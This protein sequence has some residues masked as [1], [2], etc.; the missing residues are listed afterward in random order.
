MTEFNIKNGLV[1]IIIVAFTIGLLLLKPFNGQINSGL[2]ILLVAA[3]LWISEAIHLTATALLI[4]LM[5]T[6]LGVFPIGEALENFSHPIIFIFIGGFSLAAALQHVGLDKKMAQKIL[7]WSKGQAMRAVI[8]LFLLTAI[9]S[10]WVS[11]TAVAALMLPLALGMI[12]RLK[13]NDSNTRVF[14]LLGIAYSASIGGIGTIVGSP[15]N[16]I[17]AASLQLSFSD[18]L[19]LGL[20]IVLIL[21]PTLLGVLYFSLKPNLPKHI[22][23]NGT[24]NPTQN[25]STD[26]KKTRPVLAIFFITVVLWLVG[27]PIGQALGIHKYFDAVVAIFAVIALVGSKQIPWKVIQEKTDWGVLI[28][29]GGGLTLSAILKATGS[30]AFIAETMA[31][32]LQGVPLI[33]LLFLLV[34]FVIFLTELTSNTAT[35]ALLVPLFISLAET[36]N[37][38]AHMLALA[39]GFAASCAF[40]LP[41]ATPPNAVVFGS[42]LV[43]QTE[44][45]KAGFKLN[46][47]GALILPLLIWLLV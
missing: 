38:P 37:V 34:A 17:V 26:T 19:V 32:Y 5:A 6:L 24:V 13:I 9:L 36:M 27:N 12:Q 41:V 18:W 1:T 8:L 21:L 35:A 30:S 44:M 20:P 3:T 46:I 10:M 23:L 16:A 7:L 43:P 28:L 14:I 33:L 42:G 47:V 39:I 4:P 25:L 45:M 22:E 11:N 2:L 31:H 15:P 29:F 40:M